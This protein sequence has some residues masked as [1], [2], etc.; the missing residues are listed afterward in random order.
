MNKLLL[1][2]AL[3]TATSTASS[4]TWE[5]TR[6]I[7][8]GADGEGTASSGT[9]TLPGNCEDHLGTVSLEYLAV[10]AK[11]LGWEDKDTKKRWK[12]SRHLTKNSVYY[13]EGELLMDDDIY[14]SIEG[15]CT[16]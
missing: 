9:Y 16:N 7:A 10:A 1:G 12:G 13:F 2:L 8:G 4:A 15:K 11:R 3:L 6:R 14:A 5:V